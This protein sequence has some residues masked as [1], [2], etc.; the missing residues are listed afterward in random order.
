MK[1]KAKINTHSDNIENGLTRLFDDITSNR[2]NKV[3]I[4]NTLKNLIVKAEYL[5]NLINL[6]D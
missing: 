2:L 5:Q 3:E 4:L 6:E 1:Y